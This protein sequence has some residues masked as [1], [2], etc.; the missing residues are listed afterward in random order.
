[1]LLDRGPSWRQGSRP[2]A[3]DQSQNLSEQ[4]FGNSDLGEPECDL[5][6]MSHDLGADLDELLPERQQLPLRVRSGCTDDRAPSSAV[7]RNA[8]MIR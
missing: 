2:Q 5:A 1:M 8:D 6:A 7:G 3:V 4:R